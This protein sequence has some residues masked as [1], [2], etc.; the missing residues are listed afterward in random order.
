MLE[1]EAGKVEHAE[2]LYINTAQMALEMV[3]H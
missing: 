3:R 1:D 2:N